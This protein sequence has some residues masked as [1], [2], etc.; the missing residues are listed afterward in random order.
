MVTTPAFGQL[1]NQELAAGHPVLLVD[2]SGCDFMGSSGLA[3]LMAAREQASQNGTHL[4]LAGLNRTVS[5]ALTATG[6]QQLFD[7]HPATEDA[8]DALSDR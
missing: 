5:R 6:L 4:A 2:F 3:A 7:I 8:L 1:L